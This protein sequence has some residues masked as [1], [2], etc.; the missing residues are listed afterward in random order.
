VSDHGPTRL[1]RL[2]GALRP[3]LPQPEIRG[4][5]LRE[6]GEDVVDE[7]SHHWVAYILAGLYA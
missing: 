6:E 2:L 4:H 1:G 5:L 3:R 7:V